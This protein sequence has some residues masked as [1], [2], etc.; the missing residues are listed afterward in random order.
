MRNFQL[1]R[2]SDKISTRF[3]LNIT[4]FHFNS[5]FVRPRNFK[6]ASYTIWKKELVKEWSLKITYS[7]SSCGE[8]HPHEV[9]R[10][11]FCTID[12]VLLSRTPRLSNKDFRLLVITSNKQTNNDIN[13]CDE[14][15][16][17]FS[18]EQFFHLKHISCYQ[19]ET[20]MHAISSSL[21]IWR[22]DRICF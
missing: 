4:I 9:K 1:R 8:Y 17:T 13:C 16:N 21:V 2:R 14:I 12:R 19:L 5:F 7:L 10:N 18:S 3:W 20:F 15:L 6:N 22:S 11:S